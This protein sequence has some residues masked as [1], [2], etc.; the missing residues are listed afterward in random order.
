MR[1]R[2]TGRR[3]RRR[4]RRRCRAAGSLR[5]SPYRSSRRA[6]RGRAHPRSARRAVF[7]GGPGDRRGRRDLAVNGHQRR[8]RADIVEEEEVRLEADLAREGFRGGFAEEAGDAESAGVAAGVGPRSRRVPAWRPWCLGRHLRNPRRGPAWL[9]VR[10]RSSTSSRSS[11][12]LPGGR[13]HRRCRGHWFPEVTTASRPCN[14]PDTT[15]IEP[16]HSVSTHD[17]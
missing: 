10:T 17:G 11:S 8:V 12:S 4:P 3:W 6:G 13:R 7:H 14:N 15:N 1:T 16:F 5:Q 2:R 9:P